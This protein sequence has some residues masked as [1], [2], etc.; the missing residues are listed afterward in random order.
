MGS[1]PKKQVQTF[2]IQIILTYHYFNLRNQLDNFFTLHLVS[3][4]VSRFNVV[5]K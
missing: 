2:S 4:V 3:N 1:I 5:Y